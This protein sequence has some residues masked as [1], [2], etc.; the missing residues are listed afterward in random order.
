[1]WFHWW[2]GVVISCAW[3]RVWVVVACVSGCAGSVRSQSACVVAV[4]ISVAP[5][6][7]EFIVLFSSAVSCVVTFASAG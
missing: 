2:Y 5:G 6:A 7:P 3:G 4:V 1:M